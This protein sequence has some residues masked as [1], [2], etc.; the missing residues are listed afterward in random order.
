MTDASMK[1]LGQMFFQL[2]SVRKDVL[3]SLE[4]F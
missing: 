4:V 2:Y 1:D 3:G